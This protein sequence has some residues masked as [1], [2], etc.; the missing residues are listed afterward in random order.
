MLRRFCLH[1]AGFYQ[2]VCLLREAKTLY[3]YVDLVAIEDR[4]ERQV[5]IEEDDRIGD[6]QREG[7]DRETE[8]KEQKKRDSERER[9]AIILK[10][11]DYHLA[12]TERMRTGSLLAF[13]RT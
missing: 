2:F 12:K 13:S 3:T 1:A 11:H 6:R 10:A 4:G 5:E 8:K 7:K 9:R